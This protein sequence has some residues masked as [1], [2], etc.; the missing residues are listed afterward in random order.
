MMSF[1]AFS[2]VLEREKGAGRASGG[3]VPT[4]GSDNEK[5][6]NNRDRLN[7]KISWISAGTPRKNQT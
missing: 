2:T 6:R 7:Q 1:G 5:V 4:H 3:H